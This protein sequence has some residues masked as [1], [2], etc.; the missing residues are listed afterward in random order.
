MTIKNSR[1]SLWESAACNGIISHQLSILTLREA[2]DAISKQ[3]NDRL[4]F[5]A[6]AAA[7]IIEDIFCRL[8]G[9]F[10]FLVIT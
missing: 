7:C 8:K 10:Y 3:A 1:K 4:I 2:R 6:T 9:G 5:V